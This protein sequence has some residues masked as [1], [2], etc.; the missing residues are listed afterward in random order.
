MN[1]IAEQEHAAPLLELRDIS[2]QYGHVDAL[3]NASFTIGRNEVVGLLGDNGAGKSTLVKIMSGVEFPTSGKILRDGK[4]VSIR[5][6]K[7]SERLGIETI[8][9]DSALVGSASI[10]RNFFAGRELTRGLGI[11]NTARMNEIVMDQLM[12]VV[13]ISGINSPDIPVE[14][15]SGG[16]RQAVAIARAVYFKTAMLLLDEPTSALS[17]RETDKLLAHLSE[18]KEEGVSAVFITHNLY[19]AYESCDRF[20]I[21]SRGRVI[22]NLA[23]AETSV[24]E[25]NDII[26]KY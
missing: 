25:L 13:R 20:T 16:Q 19:H 4:E 17:V 22:R 24:S 7:D 1:A 23:K 3:T 11:L 10:M 12:N 5:S 14:A 21:L 6:R 9:Q 8:Y 15:L 2:K 26:V 18:L